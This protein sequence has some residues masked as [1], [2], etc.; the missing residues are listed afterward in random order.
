MAEEF[1]AW[2]VS[3]VTGRVPLGVHLRGA[4]LWI[5][6]VTA[7]DSLQARLHQLERDPH[8][9]PQVIRQLRGVLDDLEL[10]AAA[11]RDW[12]RIRNATDSVEVLRGGRDAGSD[13]LPHRWGVAEAAASLNCSHR[14]VTA[15]IAQGRLAAVK[16][17]REWRIEVN[18]IADYKRRGVEAA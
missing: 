11:Y 3:V 4:P 10:G 6:W 5:V 17:R 18:S 14:W 13:C 12:E 8:V 7:R 1:E 9:N 16:E 15:L 2:G